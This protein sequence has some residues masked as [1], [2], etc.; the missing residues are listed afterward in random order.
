MGCVSNT[1]FLFFAPLILYF[2]FGL[3][4]FY[5]QLVPAGTGSPKVRGY[6]DQIR[7]NRF[8]FMETKSRL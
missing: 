7:N 4:E 6:V 5:N 1:N 2:I 8:Y 3:C